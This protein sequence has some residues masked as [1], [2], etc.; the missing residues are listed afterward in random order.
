M[1]MGLCPMQ[2]LLK[3]VLNIYTSTEDADKNSAAASLEKV[4][5]GMEVQG[6]VR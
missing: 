2:E 1:L 3:L 4:K 6:P 5:E